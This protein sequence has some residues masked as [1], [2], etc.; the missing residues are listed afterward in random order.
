MEQDDWRANLAAQLRQIRKARRM[1]LEDLETRSGISSSSL[2]AYERGVGNPSVDTM[3][4]LSGAL[5]VSISQLLGEAEETRRSLVLDTLWMEY[6]AE[7]IRLAAQPDRRETLSRCLEL[8]IRCLEAVR[9]SL[10]LPEGR[11]G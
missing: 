10:S 3:S 9:R 7:M 1:T 11:D 5:S 8:H 2:S 6:T 4:R